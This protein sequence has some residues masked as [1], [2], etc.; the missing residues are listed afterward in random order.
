MMLRGDVTYP[1]SHSKKE[2]VKTDAELSDSKPH[3][4]FTVPYC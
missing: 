1:R 3:N 4:F 2:A